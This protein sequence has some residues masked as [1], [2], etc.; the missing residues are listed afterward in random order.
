MN[1]A[2]QP[3]SVACGATGLSSVVHLVLF[4][5]LCAFVLRDARSRQHL[6]PGSERFL[7][8]RFGGLFE[9]SAL[10]VRKAKAEF[11]MAWNVLHSGYS[12]TLDSDH[13]YHNRHHLETLPIQVLLDRCSSS[14][15]RTIF[16]GTARWVWN[17]ALAWRSRC[18]KIADEKVSG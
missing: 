8:V 1:N 7:A 16:F 6:Q 5:V 13:P 11:R 4:Q 2:L 15:A 9:D 10:V 3:G 18:Y 14:V 17:T 12:L